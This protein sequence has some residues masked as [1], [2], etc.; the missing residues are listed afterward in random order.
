MTPSIYLT[1]AAPATTT[2]S[3]DTP[4]TVSPTAAAVMLKITGTAGTLVADA[5]MAF[6]VKPILTITIPN[7]VGNL[8][9]GNDTYGASPII[10][11]AGGVP[12]IVNFKNGDVSKHVIHSS[13]TTNGFFHGDTNPGQEI[14]SGAMDKVR[15]VTG[16]GSYPFYLHDEGPLH[17]GT[18]K[19]Q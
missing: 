15:T 18:I 19:I 17:D 3:L 2:L 16:T 14:Q 1:G 5:P 9:G 10:V 4:S 11:N 6:D 12:I 8:P 13:N 7:D